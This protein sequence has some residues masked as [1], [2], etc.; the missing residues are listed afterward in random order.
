MKRGF[1]S[2]AVLMALAADA[3]LL[4]AAGKVADG[5][6]TFRELTA[7]V[8]IEADAGAI[9]VVVD[10]TGSEGRPD[11]QADRVYHLMLSG[12]VVGPERF[13]GMAK[14]VVWQNGMA[15]TS[16]AD[17]RAIEIRLADAP[18]GYEFSKALKVERYAGDGFIEEVGDLSRF[19]LH[20]LDLMGTPSGVVLDVKDPV[21]PPPGGGG[22][23]G[24]QQSCSV[25]CSSGNSC[26]ASCSATRSA[27]CECDHG[28]A[29]CVC[30]ACIH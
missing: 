9:V 19:S 8:A 30:E 15:I 18:E 26:Q 16:L 27:R 1:L 13:R 24:C 11:G 28:A 10:E 2:A 23:G 29:V 22:G 5:A 21:D 14:L 4:A 3:G 6:G 20:G 25:T 17:A 12:K 7:D